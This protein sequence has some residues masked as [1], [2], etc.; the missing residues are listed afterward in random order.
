MAEGGATTTCAARGE[1]PEHAIISIARRACDDPS[2]A[3]QLDVLQR[4]DAGAVL[5][6]WR[7]TEAGMH[8]ASFFFAPD[9]FTWANAAEV[10]LTQLF[11]GPSNFLATG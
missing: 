8:T 7:S 3:F 10:G 1:S 9:N 2:F 6:L 11:V 4:C 5:R